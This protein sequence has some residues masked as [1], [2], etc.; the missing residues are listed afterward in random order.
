ME[1]REKEGEWEK[2]KDIIKRIRDIKWN[3]FIKD[4]TM[5]D[6]EMQ[7]THEERFEDGK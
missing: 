2:S 7:M 1:E 6:V 3:D 4:G 5:K